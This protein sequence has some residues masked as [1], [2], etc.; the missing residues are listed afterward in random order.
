[1]RERNYHGNILSSTRTAVTVWRSIY[2]LP[3]C[4][5][6]SLYSLPS[7]TLPTLTLHLVT[8]RLYCTLYRTLKRT[9]RHFTPQ[10]ENNGCHTHRDAMRYRAEPRRSRHFKARGYGSEAEKRVPAFDVSSITRASTQMISSISAEQPLA[11]A[12]QPLAS[13]E[14]PLVSAEQPAVPCALGR[15]SSARP[16]PT[17]HL[18]RCALSR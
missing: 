2:L 6:H 13:A 11:S 5:L 10:I 1:M 8:L 14:Q 16:T 3:L 9:T 18:T 12:E 4:R 17:C 15:P 7:L